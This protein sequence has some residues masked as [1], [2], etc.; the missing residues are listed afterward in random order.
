[1][2]DLSPLAYVST[3]LR[4]WCEARRIARDGG[5]IV[6]RWFAWKFYQFTGWAYAKAALWLSWEQGKDW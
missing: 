2:A 4:A 3:L 1:M 6:R 5:K